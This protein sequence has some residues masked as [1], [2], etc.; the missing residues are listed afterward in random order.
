MPAKSGAIQL[1][2]R[3]N[4]IRKRKSLVQGPTHTAENVSRSAALLPALLANILGA[5]S[6]AFC[7]QMKHTFGSRFAKYK[8]ATFS[9]YSQAMQSAYMTSTACCPEREK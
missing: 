8:N 3:A 4:L 9:G 2:R 5:K 7:E 1:P 6:I